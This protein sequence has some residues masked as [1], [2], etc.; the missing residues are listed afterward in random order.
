[1]YAPPIREL[2]INSCSGHLKNPDV[3][4]TLLKTCFRLGRELSKPGTTSSGEPGLRERDLRAA[5]GRRR[6]FLPESLLFLKTT[7]EGTEGNE[8]GAER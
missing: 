5:R 4:A 2:G 8:A 3:A 7:K 1:M 6:L